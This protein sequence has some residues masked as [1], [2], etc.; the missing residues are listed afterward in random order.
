MTDAMTHVI[1]GGGL[2]GAKAAQALREEGFEGSIVLVSAEP[3]LPYERPPLS[4]DYLRGESPREKARVHPDG[5][6]EENSI[7]LRT[8]VTVDRIDAAAASLDLAGGERLGYDRLLL[9][10]GAGPR[11]LPVAGAELDGVHYLRDLGDS[12]AIAARLR[13]GGRAVVIGAGWIGSEVAAS[14]RTL[15]LD[16]ALVEMA[17]VPLEHVIGPEAGQMFADLHR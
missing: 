9:A 3:E 5:F 4:K 10:P 15:G 14:A 7:E 12:D 6:Y 2:A 8:G 1:V 13:A 16:V 17:Q 11:R